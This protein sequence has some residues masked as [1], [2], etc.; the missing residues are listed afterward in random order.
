MTAEISSSVAENAV[1]WCEGWKKRSSLLIETR[2]NV[3]SYRNLNSHGAES[4]T[5]KLHVG[6]ALLPALDSCYCAGAPTQTLSADTKSTFE[7]SVRSLTG[8]NPGFF[9]GLARNAKKYW[10]FNRFAKSSK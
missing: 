2:L 10:W 1:C 6:R 3:Q 7:V 8:C 5:P 9:G 4:V